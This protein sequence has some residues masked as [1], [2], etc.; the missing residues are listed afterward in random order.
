MKNIRENERQKE[1]ERRSSGVG[2]ANAPRVSQY[3]S[4]AMLQKPKL[5]DVQLQA[6]PGWTNAG[7]AGDV[8][9]RP[10]P[11]FST[12]FPLVDL[13]QLELEKAYERE[14]TVYLRSPTP[15]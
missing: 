6:L 7:I 1:K 14:E 3:V 2:A 4:E 11:G 15:T 10:I 5:Q 13:F 8:S 12:L 9:G